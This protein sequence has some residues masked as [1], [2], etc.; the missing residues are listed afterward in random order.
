MDS[1]VGERGDQ[2]S[3]RERRQRQIARELLSQYLPTQLKFETLQKIKIEKLKAGESNTMVCEQLGEVG[4]KRM[5]LLFKSEVLLDKAELTEVQRM[6]I[7]QT[8]YYGKSL[9]YIAIKLNYS[10]PHIKRLK[11]QALEAIGSVIEDDTQ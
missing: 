8:Y 1:A 2:M 6:I 7:E 9:E 10:I 4:D 3:D 11:A 5:R